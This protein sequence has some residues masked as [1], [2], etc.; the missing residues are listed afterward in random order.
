MH[1][2]RARHIVLVTAP[3]QDLARLDQQ[4]ELPHHHPPQR[5]RIFGFKQTMQQDA[6]RICRPRS[7]THRQNRTPIAV[8]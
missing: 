5:E 6:A 7:T 3:I 4:T 8:T 1:A 2:Q